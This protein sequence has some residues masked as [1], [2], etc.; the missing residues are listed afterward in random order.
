MPLTFE[1]LPSAVEQLMEKVEAM[2]QKVEAIVQRDLTLEDEKITLQ[3]ALD[4]LKVSPPTLMRM[5]R[6][7]D[8][9]VYYEQGTG[10]PYFF[11]RELVEWMKRPGQ[12]QQDLVKLTLQ[13]LD[14]KRAGVA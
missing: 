12:A 4:V 5:R 6:E 14:R 1:Q 2:L 8:I 3:E 10:K 11:R 13:K 9:P 7:T